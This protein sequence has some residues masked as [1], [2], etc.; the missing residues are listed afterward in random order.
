MNAPDRLL[1]QASGGW[2][3][4]SAP[5]EIIAAHT[6]A[7][8]KPALRQV[9]AAVAGGLHAVGWLAYEAAPAFDPAFVCRPPAPGPLLWFALCDG[10]QPADHELDG[11]LDNFR[12]SDWQP[13]VD[14]A[15]YDAAIAA[16]HEQIAAGDTYQVNHTFRLRATFD[17]DPLSLLRRMHQAQRGGHGALL[18]TGGLT[19]VSASPELFFRRHGEQLTCR[20]MKGTASRGRWLEEDRERAAW[21]AG[22]EKNRAENLMIVD[23]LRNDLGRIA[24]TGSVRVPAL[25]EVERYEQVWQM[26]ST[27]TAQTRAGFTDILA[28]LFP[29][30]SITGAPKVRTMAIIAELETAPR[31]V[32]T[33]CLGYLEPSGQA[34]FN[35]AIRTVTIAP[36]GQA[37]FGV[38]GGIVWDSTADSEWRECG[39]KALVLTRR[40][41]AFEL[42][43]TLLWRPDSGYWL[44]SRH[45]DRIT[46]SAEYFGFTH[47]RAAL[48]EALT[49]SWSGGPHRVKLLLRRDG[50]ITV[51]AVPFEFSVAPDR[52]W[53]V[54]L[55][56]QPVDSQ[57]R[58]LYHKHTVRTL[59][60]EA[61]AAHPEVDEVLLHNERG[62]LTEGSFTNLVVQLDGRKLTPARACGLLPGI[63]REELLANGEIAE[64]VLPIEALQQAEAIW[65]LNSLRGW[66]PAVLA[67]LPLAS[68]GE[69]AGGG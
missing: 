15:A 37:T 44:R 26:T 7:D 14:R 19:I 4:Y 53:Q 63:F 20:P 8:V 22:D 33:G 28:A 38:G 51:E 30:A 13:S 11:D 9:E 54:C 56:D 1:L 58:L 5:S 25:F 27:V 17:G 32:Y 41:P 64:A 47:D 61:K 16:I 24:E 10:Y 29:C 21:L 52:P 18:E 57:D 59:Y 67:G 45:L 43:E 2:R 42:M 48:D 69:G 60:N 39:T 55:A 46:R 50:H 31:G 36:D 62:E 35:V 68:C 3:R 49:P 23:M 40:R 66:I 65:L 34:S 12:L 6:L